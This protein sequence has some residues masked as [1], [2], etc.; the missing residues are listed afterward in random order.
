MS[1]GRNIKLYVYVLSEKDISQFSREMSF[2]FI[3]P[4]FLIESP[5]RQ[6][7]PLNSG[8]LINIQS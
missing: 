7:I 4:G 2:C 5:S 8:R 3:E 6:I 1:D